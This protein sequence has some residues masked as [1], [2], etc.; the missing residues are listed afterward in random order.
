MTKNR[1]ISVSSWQMKSG[2]PGVWRRG[3]MRK[4]SEG[5]RV[6]LAEGF[7]GGLCEEMTNGL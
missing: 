6:L 5:R 3:E 4:G 7:R 1:K 2:D